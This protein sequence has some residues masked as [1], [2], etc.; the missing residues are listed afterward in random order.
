MHYI[1]R[2]SFPKIDLMTL[3]HHGDQPPVLKLIFYDKVYEDCVKWVL[4]EFY[5]LILWRVS[6]Q[7]HFSLFLFE[8]KA[9]NPI[10]T[11]YVIARNAGVNCIRFSSKC[12]IFIRLCRNK[13]IMAMFRR[14]LFG[15]VFTQT[16]IKLPNYLQSKFWLFG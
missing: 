4:N 5:K 15:K 8:N 13:T 1:Q 14:N 3:G 6:T 2:Y 10:L 11:C 7:L 12:Y 16:D 9:P